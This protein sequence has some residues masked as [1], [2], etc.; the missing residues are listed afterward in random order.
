M[1]MMMMMMTTTIRRLLGKP[2]DGQGET[3]VKSHLPVPPRH[4]GA[5]E[6]LEGGQR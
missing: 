2:N 6:V 1:M 3:D 4:A 5:P